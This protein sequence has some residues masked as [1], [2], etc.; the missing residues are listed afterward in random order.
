M[1]MMKRDFLAN[2][3]SVTVAG[4]IGNIVELPFTFDAIS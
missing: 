2:N 1:V 3:D 4:K